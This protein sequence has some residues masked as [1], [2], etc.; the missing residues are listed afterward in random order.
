MSGRVNIVNKNILTYFIFLFLEI[1]EE[2]TLEEK[3]E[4]LMQYVVKMRVLY[5]AHVAKLNLE[6]TK[7]NMAHLKK[8]MKPKKQTA[9]N[10]KQVKTNGE[11]LLREFK[12]L[13]VIEKERIKKQ[14]DLKSLLNVEQQLKNDLTGQIIRDGISSA[15]ILKRA[16][17]KMDKNKMA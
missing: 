3:C 12:E 16:K 1:E 13:E 15:A 17:L 14:N 6:I 8:Q 2:A 11:L 9:D 5:P 10:R 7:H 4:Q